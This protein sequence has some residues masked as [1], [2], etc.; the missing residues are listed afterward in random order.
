MQPALCLSG[1]HGRAADQAKQKTADAA[2]HHADV[3]AW[4][5]IADAL[6][7]NGIPAELLSEALTPMNDALAG[8]AESARWPRV[9]IESEMEITADGR[10]YGLLSESEQWRCDAM[11]AAA[12]AQLSDVR[13]LVLDRFDVLDVASRGDLVIWLDDL[14]VAGD[15]DTALIFGTLK[16]LPSNLPSTIDAHW[17]HA[18]RVV[19]L[20]TA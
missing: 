18:G 2:R 8:H 5:S 12:I 3:E 13:L 7:P 17:L 1:Q 14:A 10:A 19:Q 6:S 15:I 9:A 20:E 11:L 4:E 16:T